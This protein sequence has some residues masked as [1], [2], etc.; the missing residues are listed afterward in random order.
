MRIGGAFPFG[1]GNVPVGLSGGEQWYLPP[2][3]FYI[4]MGSVSVLQVFDGINQIWRNIGFPGGNVQV[5]SADGF[6]YRIV[7]MSGVVGGIQ[8][9]NAGSGGTNGIG[10]A[11][12]G[13]TIGFGSA[14]ANGIAASAY[15]IVGGKLSG[16]TIANGG[17]GFVFP[18]VLL[19]DPPPLGGIQAT[20]TCT[21]SAGAINAVT[22]QNAGAGYAANPNVYIVPQYL[23]PV[24]GG[25]PINATPPASIIPP[26]IIAPLAG[27]LSSQPPFM[28][29]VQWPAAAIAGTGA[30]ITVNGLTGS[31]TLTG[32][33][34]TQY[35]VGYTG[36]TI[37]TIS[38]AGGGLAGGVAAT[39]IMSLSVISLGTA[40]TAGAG[41]TVG[42]PWISDIGELAGPPVT[43]T[44]FCNGVFQPRPARGR[45]QATT[46]FTGTAA[47]V[48]DPGFGIQSVPNIGTTLFTTQPATVS[49]TTAVMGGVF[50]I[51]LI[52]PGVTD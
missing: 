9:T 15:P 43:N 23:L 32:A 17:S 21:I 34:V 46:G 19:L 14:P 6:N 3:N 45:I 31:G 16:L 30:S 4:Q 1:Q 50:D 7:N 13:T 39:A 33:V 36:T 37:P 49:T 52:Q 48:E 25:A 27:S 2:G 24:Q 41:Y 11:A 28:P 44:D 12:T 40:G 20:A 22:L 29:G 8:I 51:C 5:T 18:P 26:G 42:T 47:L 35:G 38:F 10:T